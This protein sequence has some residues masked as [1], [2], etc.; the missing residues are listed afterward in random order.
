MM[1]IESGATSRIRSETLS[2]ILA[3]VLRRSSRLIPGLRAIPA[4]TTKISLPSAR[5]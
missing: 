3:F 2:T 4:V 5:P 1:T